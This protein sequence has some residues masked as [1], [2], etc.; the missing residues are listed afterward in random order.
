MTNE[1]KTSVNRSI[2]REEMS[3]LFVNDMDAAIESI[4]SDERITALEWSGEIASGKYLG[5]FFT[6]QIKS[7]Q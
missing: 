3:V 1:I 5:K 2:A 4:S 7:N 6:I